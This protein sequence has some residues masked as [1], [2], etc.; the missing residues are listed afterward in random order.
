MPPPSPGSIVI[1]PGSSVS[2]RT[3]CAN[4]I[5]AASRLQ[6]RR[7]TLKKY[8][9]DRKVQQYQLSRCVL[10]RRFGRAGSGVLLSTV[11]LPAEI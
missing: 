3:S 4:W 1:E 2:A 5:S 7:S 10:M 6:A 11:D 9:S 8:R